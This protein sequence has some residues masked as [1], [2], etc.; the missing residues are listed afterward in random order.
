MLYFWLKFGF[1]AIT[2]NSLFF[3]PLIS[4]NQNKGVVTRDGVGPPWLGEKKWE[5]WGGLDW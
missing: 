1:A 4:G 5:F 2:S 3:F